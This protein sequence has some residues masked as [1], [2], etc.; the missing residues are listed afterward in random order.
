MKY[1]IEYRIETL[2]ENAVGLATEQP[3]FTLNDINF[4]HWEF[5]HRD[6]WLADA[7]L[8]E[9]TI[10]A[11]NLENAY[12]T[13]RAKMVRIV[14]RIAFVSQCYTELLLQPFL[15]IKEGADIG[16]FYDAFDET[17]SGLMFMDEEKDALER[18]LTSQ[19]DDAFFFY[20]ND[21]VNSIGYT[22][23]LLLMFSALEALAKKPNGDKDWAMIE[24]ILG[25]DLKDEIFKPTEGPRHRLT[26]GEYLNQSDFPGNYAEVIHKKVMEYFNK[27]VLGA[28]L[29][30]VDVVSPQRH[31][32]GNKSVG[33]Y[34]IRPKN[35]DTP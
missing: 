18:L 1:K 23:K 30:T 25:K 10:D 27:N 7:W 14:P 34:F 17:H 21:A 22:P 24:S 15:I 20:W 33:K 28:D 13:F 31:F 35:S 4:S 32:F 16:Y 8:A 12:Q 5:N 29:L 11:D 19:A 2:A 3:F 9:A 6:G 26:H